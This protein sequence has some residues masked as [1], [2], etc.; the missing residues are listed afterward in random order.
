MLSFIKLLGNEHGK[1]NSGDFCRC[2]I[3]LVHFKNIQT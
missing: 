3:V 1:A 2:T